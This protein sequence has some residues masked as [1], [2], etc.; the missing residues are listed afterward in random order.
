[1]Q[2]CHGSSNVKLAND[3]QQW[4]NLNCLQ[5]T[6]PRPLVDIQGQVPATSNFKYLSLPNTLEAKVHLNV[7]EGVAA[8]NSASI[9][10]ISSQAYNSSKQTKSQQIGA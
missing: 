5:S 8:N 4:N 7:D 1:M 3:F 10:P 2:T 6:P 9:E